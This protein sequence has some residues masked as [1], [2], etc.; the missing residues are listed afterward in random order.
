VT[1]RPGARLAALAA[2]LAVT[3]WSCGGDDDPDGLRVRDAWARTTPAGVSVGAVYLR[4]TSDVADE[5]LGA[6][7]DDTV[8]ASVELHATEQAD[9]GTTTMSEQP[10]LPVP[11]GGELVLE[12]I[13]N[14]LMLVDLADALT[15]GETFELTLHFAT[16]GDQVVEVE[17][18]EGPP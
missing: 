2:T 12:P 10:S 15:T 9:D 7:V 16:A 14:H 1:R 6:A 11:A 4:V 8:A 18:R 5:L 13:G 3:A 17:V